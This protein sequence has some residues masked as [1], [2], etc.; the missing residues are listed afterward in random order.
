MAIADPHLA[1]TVRD[2]RVEHEH[3][4]DVLLTAAVQRRLI[5]SR[6]DG[7]AATGA[8]RRC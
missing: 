8:I 6:P 4:T 3:L 7:D 2:R 5:A 1:E